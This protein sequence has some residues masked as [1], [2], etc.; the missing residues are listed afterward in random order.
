MLLLDVHCNS[1][2]AIQ[3]QMVPVVLVSLVM[4]FYISFVEVYCS[5]SS[6]VYIVIP[7]KL[8]KTSI[9]NCLG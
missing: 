6:L 8:T 4:E 3:N 7:Q 1:I 2:Y 9:S 5:Y